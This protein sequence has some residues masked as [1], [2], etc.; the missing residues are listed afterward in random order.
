MHSSRCRTHRHGLPRL[1]VALALLLCAVAA[2]AYERDFYFQKLDSGS[3]LAQNSVDVI[4]QDSRGYIWLATEGG[5]HRF[6]GYSLR[7]FQHDPDRTDSLPD[8]LVTALADAGDGKL[9][10]GSHSGGLVL[11]DPDHDRALPLPPAALAPDAYVY[12]LQD[13]PGGAL[14]VSDAHGIERIG[15]PYA[16]SRRLW[17]NPGGSESVVSAFARCPDDSVYAAAAHSVLTLDR[18]TAPARVLADPTDPVSALYCDHRGRLLLGDGHGL[19]QIDRETGALTRLQLPGVNAPV[20]VTHIVEDH[21]GRLWLSLA[22]SGLLRLDGNGK[23]L[24]VRPP[25][26]DIP[27]GLPDGAIGGLFVDRSGLLWVGTMAHGAAWTDPDGSPFHTIINLDP[28]ARNSGGNHLRTFYEAPDGSLW[29][30]AVGDALVHYLPASGTFENFGDVLARAVAVPREGKAEQVEPDSL[31]PDARVPLRVYAILPDGG[32]KLLVASSRGLLSFDPQARSAVLLKLPDDGDAA[33]SPPDIRA[34]LRAR[35]GD[36]WLARGDD[37]LLQY[38]DGKLL[39]HYRA[40]AD[41]E[42]AI[43]SSI[44]LTLAEDGMGRIWAGTIDGLS[45]IDP[46]AQKVRNFHELPGRADS[47]SGHTVLDVMIGKDATVWVGTLSGLDRLLWIDDAG[48]HFRRYGTRDGMPDGTTYCM[49]ED[50]HGDVWF[51]TNLGIGRLDQ[52]DGSIRAFQTSDG[53]QGDEYDSGAC[54]ALRDGRLVFGGINGFD[55]L[56][57]GALKSSAFKPPAM[58]TGVRIDSRLVA[59]PAPGDPVLQVPTGSRSLHVDF[60]AL[61]YAT[62]QRN[63]FRYRLLGYDDS[64]VDIGMRHSA[65]WTNLAPGAYRLEVQGRSRNGTFGAA[66]VLPLK[67]LAPWWSRPVMRALYAAAALLI[68]LAL[69]LTWRGKRLEELR[70]QKQLRL[71]E[72]RLRLA[73]WGSGDEFWDW[74]LHA[75]MIFRLGADGL[76]GGHREESITIDDWRNFAVHPDDLERVEHALAEHVGGNSDHFEAEH[77]LMNTRGDWV[78]VISR[79]K[80]V[81]RDE[82]GRPL[83][84]CGTARDISALRA[85]ERDRRVAAEVI[86]SMT[87]AVTVTDLNYH[88]ISVNPAFTRMTGYVEEEVIGRDAAL[89]NCRQH[90]PEI[91]HNVRN[92]L[93]EAGHWRGEMWQRRKDGEEFLCW[94]EINQVRDSS[95]QPSH[96]VCVLTDITDRKRAEQELRYLANYDTLTG[97]PN[98]TLLGER[99]GHAII[100]ARRGSHKVAVLF[101]DLDRFKHVND[102]MG[103]AAGDR[104]LKAAGARLRHVVR[105]QDTVARLGGDEFTVILEEV[106]DVRDAEEMAQRLIE[107]FQSPLGLGGSQEVV[108]SPSI[109]ISIYPDHGQVPTDLLKYADT[110]MYQAKERGRNTYTVYHARMDAQARDRARL[111]AALRRAL[112]RREFELVYQPKMAIHSGRITGVEALLR[113][114]SGELGAIPPTV[115]I[116]LAE[117]TGLIHEIGE[118]V[119]ISACAAL[120]DFREAGLHGITMAVNLSA[121]QLQ[122][123]ELTLRMCE[124]L[125]DYD[126][127]PDQLELELTESMVMANAEQSVRILTELKSIGVRLAIDDFGTGYSSLVYLKRLPIDTLKIDREFVGDITTDPDDASITSTIITM[128][129][130]LELNVIAEGVETPEQLAFL[131]SQ[132]CDEIQGHWFSMPLSAE[133]CLKFIAARCELARAGEPAR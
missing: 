10:V 22:G 2:Q 32:G 97:L 56:D 13:L 73:L 120:K 87:E 63:H 123:A 117:E 39:H 104:M 17:K 20:R 8:N 105:E 42:N 25:Q 30:G 108:I 64:W 3:G 129:H 80:I 98:R 130:S 49:L 19:A 71:R 48:A 103:H 43:A 38:R 88:F 6:D 99:L 5:L 62:P 118:F 31:L 45:L 92:V 61:D 44:V 83:R 127:A 54:L 113:W 23:A 34:L 35:N 67:V 128:A 131:R 51:S 93:A 112:E 50:A 46:S 115:F 106:L 89:L 119:L 66:A 52:R 109:G 26:T 58:I 18:G 29:L 14:L 121:A 65:T 122:R 15:V 70:H 107:A 68:V 55:V 94:I 132:G 96:I 114:N 75:G 77:R 33:G 53:L 84:I 16:R 37:G 111:I 11:F 47:L 124:I 85:A 12:A 28:G 7:R 40:H 4:A 21:A 27:G 1:L 74:D 78:W 72:D 59:A 9:W 100:N 91:Y 95:G 36:L 81:E 76:P 79:G 90:A 116:P 126:I 24:S 86:R 60:A 69:V 133:N 82:S 101:I 57:V 102:S 41:G 125:A 110:A